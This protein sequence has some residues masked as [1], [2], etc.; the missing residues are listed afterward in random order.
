MSAASAVVAV[1]IGGTTVKGLVRAGDVVL[2]RATVPTFPH[3]TSEQAR[4]DQ[5]YGS[6]VALV[7]QLAAAAERAGHR[8]AGIGVCTPGLVDP[9]SGRIEVAVNL[10]WTGLPIADLLGER[11]G[12]PVAVDHDARA[13]AYAEHAARVAAGR[14]ADHMVV[15]P[16]GTGIAGALVIDG[17]FVLGAT[18]AAGELGHVSVVPGG[19]LC[20]CG[21]RG[22]VEVYA[23]AGNIRRRYRAAGGTI[24]GDTEDIVA[25]IDSDPV[26]AR[27]WD[28]AIDALAAG[29]AMLAAVLDP[30]VVVIGGGLGQAG[31][32]LLGPLRPRVDAKLGW[33]P[34]PRIEQS[35]V[36]SEAGLAG[37]ALLAQTH[38]NST[39]HADSTTHAQDRVTDAPT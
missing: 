17:R 30:D 3:P 38:A 34:S 23:S 7:A 15:I 28:D 35:L 29:I 16:I 22:C 20:T 27:V 11:F 32:R 1:D 18:G 14:P 6:V 5:A 39:T 12:V 8:L 19:D 26:A 2:E 33:R 21:Q 31:E 13:A 36:G 9:D 10:G 25:A 4:G 24:D 37:A